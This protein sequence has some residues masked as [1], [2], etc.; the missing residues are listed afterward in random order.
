MTH[1]LVAD[2]RERFQQCVDHVSVARGFGEEIK[3]VGPYFGDKQPQ[4]FE[5]CLAEIAET[6]R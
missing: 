3:F 4:V 2:A 5:L 1:V 6:F